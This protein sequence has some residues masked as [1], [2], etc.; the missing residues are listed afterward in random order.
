MGPHHELHVIDHDEHG[1]HSMACGHW[2]GEMV[3]MDFS[4]RTYH[5]AHYDQLLCTL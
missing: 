5:H 4:S 2:L 1:M 3:A